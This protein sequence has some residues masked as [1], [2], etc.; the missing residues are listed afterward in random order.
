MA[1]GA[2]K[3]FC[4]AFRNS[5]GENSSNNDIQSNSKAVALLN[6]IRKGGVGGV[7]GRKASTLADK[8]QLKLDSLRK[9]H[10]Q[11]SEASLEVDEDVETE[12]SL[13]NDSGSEGRPSLESVEEISEEIPEDDEEDVDEDEDEVE[14]AVEE[15]EQLGGLIVNGD[16]SQSFSQN[17]CSKIKIIMPFKKYS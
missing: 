16:G 1:L 17:D 14:E 11:L 15:E 12:T 13:R 9:A 10:D 4:S 8:F 3:V 7:G 5:T 6:G 2:F